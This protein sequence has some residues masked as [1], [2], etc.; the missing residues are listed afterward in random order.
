MSIQ[1][2]VV[3][4]VIADDHE[5][6]REG[7][8]LTLSKLPEVST[9]AEASNGLQLIELVNKHHPDVVITDIKMPQMDGIEAVRKI[10]SKHPDI[11]IIALSMFDQDD[12]ILDML[13]AGANGYL[14]KNADKDEIAEAIRSVAVGDPYYCKTTNSKLARL[15][16]QSRFTPYNRKVKPNFSDK[17]LEIIELVCRE[18]TNKEIADKLFM[19]IRT[20]EGHRQKILEKMEVKNTVGLVIYAIQNGLVKL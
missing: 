7:V 4:V 20:V 11:G 16:A 8:K 6:F 10:K 14:L 18:L 13:E 12:L 15:I 19:S 2:K 17:E 3:R 1:G 5:I 9:L